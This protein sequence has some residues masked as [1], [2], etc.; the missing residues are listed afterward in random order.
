M[1]REI[2]RKLEQQYSYQKMQTLKQRLIKD[3]EGHNTIIKE[4]IQKIYIAIVNTYRCNIGA[5]QYVRYRLKIK[6]REIDSNT[7]RVEDF[8]T[9][10]LS[11]DRS[12]IQKINKEI[13]TL[14]DTLDQMDSA[15]FYR[16]FHSKQQNTHSSQ[17]HTECFPGL[18]T[19]WATR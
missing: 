13:Q 7:I 4:S 8:N 16:A 14:K 10:V 11:M 9:S 15:D 19:C 1:Q 3:K 2:K 5:P 6:K 18:T 12:S 17:V